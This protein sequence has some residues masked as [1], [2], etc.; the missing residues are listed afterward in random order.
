MTPKEHELLLSTFSLPA[1]WCKEAEARD[2]DGESVSY[3]DPRAVAWDLTG[4][5]CSLFGWNRAMEL[6]PQLA[7]HML[8]HRAECRGST[9]SIAC[10][11]ALQ[12]FNDSPDTTHGVLLA[13]LRRVPIWAR[14]PLRRPPTASAGPHEHPSQ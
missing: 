12:E 9:A 1:R 11:V 7:R 3:H 4:G 14:G 13:R 5:V 2:D 10:M 6:F 8:D